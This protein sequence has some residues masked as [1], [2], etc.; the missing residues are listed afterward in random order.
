[1]K[2]G[3]RA[4]CSARFWRHAA[5]DNRGNGSGLLLEMRARASA[6]RGYL[7]RIGN[8]VVDSVAFVR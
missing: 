1:M 2:M 5:T 8:D 3:G 4:D 6:C 7:R